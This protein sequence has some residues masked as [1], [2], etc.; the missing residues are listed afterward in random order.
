MDTV[1]SL[2]ATNTNPYTLTTLEVT[3]GLDW[4]AD[5]VSSPSV[6]HLYSN[7]V[8]KSGKQWSSKTELVN[9]P[10]QTISGAASLSG[11][12]SFANIVLD[13]GKVTV[14]ETIGGVATE[15][16]FSPVA[17]NTDG[18]RKNT[19][20]IFTA[21]KTFQSNVKASNVHLDQL[22][23]ATVINEV[24]L[25]SYRTNVLVTAQETGEQELEQTI[26]G[27]WTLDNGITVAGELDVKQQIA[28]CVKVEDLVQEDVYHDT[29]VIPKVRTFKLSAHTYIYVLSLRSPSMRMLLWMAML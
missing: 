6:T 13:S 20:N 16:D 28:G 5:D 9:P 17:I 19:A 11:T 8:T 21:H 2:L 26:T 14:P 3:N 22:K 4:T 24:D 1:N 10:A 29:K 7:L 12:V 15:T 25:A 23:D 18:A 27:T